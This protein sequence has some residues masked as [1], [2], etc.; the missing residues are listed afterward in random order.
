MEIWD[1]LDKNAH[2]TGKTIRRGEKLQKG[3]YHLVVHVWIKDNSEKYLISK[4]TPN[5]T[6]PNMWETTGGAAISGD[7]SM[8]TALKEV[9]EELGISLNPDNGKFLFRLKRDGGATSNFLDVWLFEE[10]IDLSKIIFQPNETC[11]AKLATKDEILE[12][13]SKGEFVNTFTYLDKIFL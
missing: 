1:I 5:K 11:D 12:M 8:Q 13:I 6:Y 2:F 3:E 10:K 7:T 9:K 4:R